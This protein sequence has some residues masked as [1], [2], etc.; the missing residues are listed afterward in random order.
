[1]HT[2]TLVPCAPVAWSRR[3]ASGGDRATVSNLEQTRRRHD[4]ERVVR[5]HGD[6]LRTLA[7]RLC[8]S[9]LDP[10]DL[11]QDV[12]EKLMRLTVPAVDNERAWLTRV[13]SHLFI[14]QVRRRRAL[15]E[16]QL[17]ELHT[18]AQL[19]EPSPWEHVTDADVRAKVALLPP[20]Q[21]TTFELFAFE[22]MSYDAIA[23]R[24]GIAKAT[25]GTRILRARQKLRVMLATNA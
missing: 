19:D 18:A 17:P 25:V 7:H 21:R 23:A 24:L 10:D 12:L 16:Q 3:Q 1:M 22:R 20:E 9:Q 15:R 6:Y 4:V 8:R 14:D 13:T 2:A 5:C 11:V